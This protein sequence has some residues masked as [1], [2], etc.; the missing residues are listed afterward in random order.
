M[1][2]LETDTNADANGDVVVHLGQP[3][4]RV[5]VVVDVVVD[6]N[7]R[8]NSFAEALDEVYGS[9]ADLDWERPAAL[10]SR[11]IEAL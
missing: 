5:H 10:P 6:D 3:G 11:E 2:R 8:V 1:D 9:C 4:A 7:K